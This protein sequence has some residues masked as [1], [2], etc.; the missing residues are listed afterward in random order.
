MDQ[1]Q[2]TPGQN[3]Y[4]PALPTPV[5]SNPWSGAAA[6]DAAQIPG[7]VQS[8]MQGLAGMQGQ[9]QQYGQMSGAYPTYP[10]QGGF[11]SQD[12]FGSSQGGSQA[13]AAGPAQESAP[14]APMAA[15]RG[16]NPW[17]LTGEANAR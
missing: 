5:N 14:A 16:F 4:L 13:I 8:G 17:S 11:G 9:M 7:Q 6:T 10:N 3:G 1:P 2:M 15:D 12:A